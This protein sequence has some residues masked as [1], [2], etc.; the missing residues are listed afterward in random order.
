MTLYVKYWTRTQKQ[1]KTRKTLITFYNNS[2]SHNFHLVTFENTLHLK[3]NSFQLEFI[4]TYQIKSRVESTMAK[5]RQKN[6]TLV[7]HLY[8][9]VG[10]D[11]EQMSYLEKKGLRSASALLQSYKDDETNRT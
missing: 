7:K 8:E 4:S 9:T 5:T 1:V 6:L 3:E 2:S 10:Y 11:D